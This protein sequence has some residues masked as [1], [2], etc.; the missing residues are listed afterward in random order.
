[1]PSRGLE[2]WTAWVAA[3][4]V[5]AATVLGALA[6]VADRDALRSTSESLWDVGVGVTF[7]LAARLARGSLAER[8][9]FGSVGV[10]W[11]LASSHSG[12]LTLH[13]SALLVALTA[14]PSGRV[15]S[16]PGWVFVVAAGASAAQLVDQVMVAALFGC[17][18]V[19]AWAPWKRWR[20]PA[21]YVV[22]A[23]ASVALAMLL[24]WWEVRDG[25]PPELT[26]YEAVLACVA[27]GFVV[28]TNRRSAAAVA[29]GASLVADVASGLVGLQSVLRRTLGDPALLIEPLEGTDGSGPGAPVDRS[30]GVAVQPVFDDGVLV[31][32]VC[33]RSSVLADPST[34]EAVAAA[35]RLT[36]AQ[37]RLLEEAETSRAGLERS[38]SRL[39]AAADREREKVSAAL[40][41]TTG[42][43]LEQATAN[44]QD[45]MGVEI[46]DSAL[47]AA[48]T[49]AVACLETARLDIVRIVHG[50]PPVELGEGRVGA[51]LTEMAAR[52]SVPVHLDFDGD[53]AAPTAIETAVFYVCSESL[54]NVHKHAGASSVHVRLRATAENVV[55]SVQD[56][57]SGELDPT[58]HGITGLADRVRAAG[59]RL[60]VR[61]VPGVGTTVVATLPVSHPPEVS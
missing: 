17:C 46:D 35:I 27:V 8:C 44:A 41:S 31:A 40:R 18:G 55:L 7:V 49:Q 11:L 2:R 1:M 25:M 60:E 14:F 19:T 36:M 23:S 51:A 54:V 47:T 21:W 57:G 10:A 61:G 56:D 45:A 34:A 29:S 53:V 22:A 42:V 12:L 26:A 37:A 32:R 59:G 43:A 58:G 33:A 5:V 3:A 48:M 30:S 38:R 4:T 52:S 24:D 20:R 9:W 50:V 13:Q 39:L 16:L 6:Y 28:V 15:R